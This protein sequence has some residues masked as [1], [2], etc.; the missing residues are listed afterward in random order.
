MNTTELNNNNKT[1][2]IVIGIL[3]VAV[4]L[5][6]AFLIYMPQTGSLGDLNVSFLPGLNAVLNAS[7]AIC[8]LI[9]L[10]FIKNNKPE[11]HKTFM[12]SAFALSSLF[13]VSYVIYHFQ[14]PPTKFGGE[15]IMKLVYFFILLTHIVLAALVLPLILFSIYYGYTNQLYLH[16]KI[17]K[18]T[19]PIWLYVAVTGPVVYLMISPYY[20]Q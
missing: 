9:G 7:V 3:S 19:Y 17:V 16:K 6:V 13:L 12:I 10:Y 2:N 5:V 11:M 1:A 20:Q 4:P 18:Y 15:G 8:L 14:A